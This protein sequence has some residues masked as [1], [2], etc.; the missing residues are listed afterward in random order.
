MR[1]IRIGVNKILGALSE[2]DK[3][4][5]ALQV[6][7]YHTLLSLLSMPSIRSINT[8][9]VAAVDDIPNLIRLAGSTVTSLRFR[10]GIVR[11]DF[12]FRIL[13]IPKVFSSFTYRG[14]AMFQDPFG[15]RFHTC[16][17]QV[18]NTVRYRHFDL[19]MEA[20]IENSDGERPVTHLHPSNTCQF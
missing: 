15:L 17:L 10:N 2:N 19:Y 1:C 18:R 14:H 3:R 4:Q 7:N 12:R 13:T 11:L 6:L 5:T 8:S 16:L 20:N 9:V